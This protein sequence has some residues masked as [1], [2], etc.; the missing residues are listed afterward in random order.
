MSLQH[1]GKPLH[2]CNIEE[3]IEFEKL[4]LKRLLGASS[5][6]MSQGIIDQLHGFLET[7]REHRDSLFAKEKEGHSKKQSAEIDDDEDFEERPQPEP[8]L[9]IGEIQSKPSDN[10]Q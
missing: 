7:V 10:T 6:G 5:A 4:I 9:I 2:E 1:N 3:T 8:G